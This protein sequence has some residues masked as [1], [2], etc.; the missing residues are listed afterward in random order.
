MM[1]STVCSS[2][3][4]S[5]SLRR[6]CLKTPF[7]LG[8]KAQCGFYQNLFVVHATA[9]FLL[10]STAIWIGIDTAANRFRTH[11][12]ARPMVHQ[13][14]AFSAQARITLIRAGFFRIEISTVRPPGARHSRIYEHCSPD[15]MITLA[16]VAVANDPNTMFV[17]NASEGRSWREVQQALELLRNAKP[18]GV[19]LE[20]A[21]QRIAAPLTR[22]FVPRREP[23]FVAY[24]FGKAS[25]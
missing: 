4:R 19:R 20:I 11:F 18:K 16:S 13:A 5:C 8:G 24:V 14:S 22:E 2:V 9:I 1:N 23:P 7:G 21:V 12:D 3:F 6:R 25:T 10:I 15:E 17:L